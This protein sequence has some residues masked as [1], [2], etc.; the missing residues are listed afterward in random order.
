LKEKTPPLGSTLHHWTV[1][2]SLT[3]TAPIASHNRKTPSKWASKSGTIYFNQCGERSTVI[4]CSV[5]A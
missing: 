2:K 4:G 1:I 3:A 5:C